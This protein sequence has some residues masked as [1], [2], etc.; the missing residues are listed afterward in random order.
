[1]ARYENPQSWF[2]RRHVEGSGGGRSDHDHAVQGMP[3]IQFQ[4]QIVD[5]RGS[6]S[7]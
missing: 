4:S 7:F 1:M 5:A 3:H 6:L 2:Q